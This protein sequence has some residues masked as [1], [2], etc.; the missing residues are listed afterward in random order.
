MAAHLP[1]VAGLLMEKEIEFLGSAIENPAKP[2]VAIIGG[3][4]ISDKIGVIR[5]LLTKVEWL[6]IGG[7][8]ANTFLHAEGYDVGVA[9][10]HRLLAHR[11]RLQEA[12]ALVV[13]AGGIFM[14][15]RDRVPDSAAPRPVAVLPAGVAPT[16]RA[17]EAESQGLTKQL[18]AAL[19]KG[20]G[21]VGSRPG[22]PCTR[23]HPTPSTRKPPSSMRCLPQAGSG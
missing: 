18:M 17:L 21:P 23:I 14:M 12:R 6:L 2:Y 3:A 22:M 4:K 1:A 13:V 5:N 20:P 19:Q 7:G 9:G 10:I 16:I 15:S 11:Q 8:M